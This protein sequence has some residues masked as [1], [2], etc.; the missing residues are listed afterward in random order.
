MLDDAVY[1][2]DA[3]ATAGSVSFSNPNL[4][5]TGDLAV[6][7]IATITYSVT[8][9]SPDPGDHVLSNTV[10][11]TAAGSNCPSGSTDTRCTVTVNVS[12]LTIIKTD[13]NVSTTAPGSTV[14]Y[15]ITVTNTGK[16][17]YAGA[18]FTDPLSDV[19][20]DAT[21]GSGSATS[22]TLRFTSPTLTWTGDLA[23]GAGATITYSVTVKNPDTGNHVLS[24]TVTSA[25]PGSNCP[26]GSTDAGCTVTVSVPGL[27][28]VKTADVS[29]T[30]PGSQVHYTITVTNTGAVILT[31]ATFAD[32]LT[33]LLD[34]ATYDTDSATV[35]AGLGSVSY[36]SPNL[37]WTG[38]LAA[39]QF[40]TIKYSVTV[41]GSDT[42]N[43]VLSNTV[44]SATAGSNCPNGGT[45]PRCT[46]TVTVASLS[47]VKTAS[48]STTTP[49]ATVGYT[50]VVTNTGPTAYTG[51]TFTDQL[52]GVLSD[53]SYN[54]DA[55]AVAFG[56]GSG[57]VVSF[58]SPNLTWTDNLLAVHAVV[59]ITYSV[60]VHNPDMGDKL[61]ANTVVS[62]TPGSNCAAGSTDVSCSALVPDLVPGL[63]IVASAVPATSPPTPGT[64]VNYTIT[65]TNTGQST[66]TGAAFTEPLGGGAG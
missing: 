19:L 11:S 53:A 42:G 28:I 16:T 12:A 56:G 40:A 5:W 46:A 7:A 64:K 34:D 35:T 15:T 3:S 52:G 24:N 59:T 32:D 6:G 47:I 36:L 18:T 54:G 61:L 23:A 45:D 31:G 38:T 4:A 66:Y 49:G 22:G 41:A 8:V 33:G 55:T 43:G 21:Y 26:S 50:I 2:G 58:A 65:V 1:N 10:T 14:N 39:G 30:T 27:T 17:A 60:T 9:R 29:T 48:V 51:A 37:T 63:D 44:T 13:A 20:D 25:T 62:A 57:G